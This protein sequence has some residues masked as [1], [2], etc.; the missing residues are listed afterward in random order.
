[1]VEK[2]DRHSENHV[3][4]VA[5]IVKAAAPSAEPKPL[6]GLPQQEIVNPSSQRKPRPLNWRPF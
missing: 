3:R 5:G 2:H 4:L 6:G 1:M